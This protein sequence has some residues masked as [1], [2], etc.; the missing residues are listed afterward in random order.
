[1]KQSIRKRR[2]DRHKHKFKLFSQT[3]GK[4]IFKLDF[5]DIEAKM[6]FFTN[7]VLPEINK[8]AVIFAEKV[9]QGLTEF[10]NSGT[11]ERS[12]NPCV[13]NS[14]NPY[15]KCAVNPLADCSDCPHYQ[16]RDYVYNS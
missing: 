4:I 9:K 2:R 6:T 7:R 8:S 3:Q 11:W 13:F 10:L 1:M 16:K 15:L 14:G 5:G 12:V